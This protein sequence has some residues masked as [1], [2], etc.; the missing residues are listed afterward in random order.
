MGLVCTCFV[1]FV[2]RHGRF[3]PSF[4]MENP[5][6]RGCY[7]GVYRIS[8][9]YIDGNIKVFTSISQSNN[10]NQISN[11]Y[12]SLLTK[13]SNVQWFFACSRGRMHESNDELFVNYLAIQGT[14]SGLDQGTVT[15]GQFGSGVQCQYVQL[16][17]V[18]TNKFISN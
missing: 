18:K 2:A 11:L 4:S 9:P 5:Y 10:Q 1:G 3:K 12:A 7:V 14:F 8:M 15:F 13:K 17:R 6:D 16:Q